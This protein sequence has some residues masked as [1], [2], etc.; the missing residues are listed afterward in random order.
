M[1][2]TGKELEFTDETEVEGPLRKLL[3]IAE[4]A[5]GPF[6]SM[7]SCCSVLELDVTR[8]TTYRALLAL[9]ILSIVWGYNW[10]V[11]K[12][13][14][15]YSG[16]FTF[17][18]LR[19]LSG[20]FALLLISL[21]MR[22][23]L[24][25][26]TFSGAMVLGLLQ[27]TGFLG[28]AN[29]ALVSGGAG[30]TAVLVY[31]MPFWVL[32]MAWPLLGERIQG[33]WQWLTVVLVFAGLM[34]VIRPWS[35]SGNLLSIILALSAGFAWGLSSIWIKHLQRHGFTDRMTLTAWQ[36]I[37]GSIPLLI[38]ALLLEH[39]AIDWAPYYIG[40]VV[41][42]GLPATA[43]AWLLFVYAMQELPAG[44]AGIGTLLTPIIGVLSAWLQLGET[45]T[46]W[47]TVGIVCIFL[48]LG[49]LSW[50]RLHG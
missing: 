32:I 41:Y 13:A 30:K 46:P 11:M 3:A 22:R 5:A 16:P 14:L 48:G 50:D 31:T 9:V 6:W 10:V 23:S 42:N 1:A 17:A 19:C 40:A 39:Q 49:T 2:H 24:S 28:L 44:T 8:N 27:T 12:E 33:W 15:K 37:L 7:A 38:V 25:P 47:E 18:T 4:A 36:L 21:V 45:P 26:G 34:L 35:F 43:L 20:G 29:W